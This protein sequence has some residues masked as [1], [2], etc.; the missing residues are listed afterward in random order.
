[1][2]FDA[3]MAISA[4]LDTEQYA[5]MLGSGPMEDLLNNYYCNYVSIF[6][7]IAEENELIRCALEYIYPP[8]GKEEDFEKRLKGL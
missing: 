5:D 4:D 7:E 6:F 2:L 1:M 8:F 3:I